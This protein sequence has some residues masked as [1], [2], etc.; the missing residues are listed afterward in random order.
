MIRFKNIKNYSP[1][2]FLRDVGI[3]LKK[4]IEILEKV[5]S[6]I[7]SEKQRN[8]LKR[9]GTKSKNGLQS[10]ISCCGFLLHASL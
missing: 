6:Y 3:P 9:R 8:P 1:S 7:E 5:E 2:L 10:P 4:F